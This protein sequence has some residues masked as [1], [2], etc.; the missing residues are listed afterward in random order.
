MSQGN[1]QTECGGVGM[2]SQ[3][4][5]TTWRR[6]WTV[7]LLIT[8][9]GVLRFDGNDDFELS[10]LI[11][12]CSILYRFRGQAGEYSVL[13]HSLVLAELLRTL[14]ES[15]PARR[16]LALLHDLPETILG[17]IPRNLVSQWEKF[18]ELEDSLLRRLYAKLGVALPS[19]EDKGVVM[20][21][22]A[23]LD[24]VEI[25]VLFP[26]NPYAQEFAARRCA[27]VSDGIES[28]ITQKIMAIKRLSPKDVY[29]HYAK[30]IKECVSNG[31]SNGCADYTV[32]SQ[33]GK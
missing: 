4:F 25:K 8:R 24:V 9:R 20:R 33:S 13:H 10:D 1:L 16:L 3:E 32:M 15:T 21:N 11:A 23:V 22:H 2:P 30:E 14:R 18:A 27:L 26:H 31:L 28:K 6:A 29:Y 5:L 17:D 7:D 12:G 19:E